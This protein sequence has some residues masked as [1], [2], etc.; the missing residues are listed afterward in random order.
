MI[1]STL[2]NMLFHCNFEFFIIYLQLRDL[3]CCYTKWVACISI[4]FVAP[5]NPIFNIKKAEMGL[6]IM[7]FS[8]VD[9]PY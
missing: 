2:Q 4:L 8:G 9:T 7:G 3:E 1:D 5:L 6:E